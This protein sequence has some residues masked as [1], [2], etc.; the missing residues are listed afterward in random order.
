MRS[1]L[2]FNF[3]FAGIYFLYAQTIP[4]WFWK[5][6]KLC[7]PGYAQVPALPG[8]AS[9][10]FCVG[11]YEAKKVGSVAVS[12]PTGTPW[13]TITRAEAVTACQANGS[14]YDLIS[15]DQWQA[16]ARN[17]ENVASNWSSGVVGSGAIN[18][19]NSASTSSV[20][21]CTGT[22]GLYGSNG[23]SGCGS[24]VNFALKRTHTL[25]NGQVIWDFAGNV[26]EWVKDANMNLSLTQYI[27]QVTDATAKSLF[28]PGGTYTSLNSG[29]YGGLGL[30]GSFSA[31]GATFRGG[32]WGEGTS[33]G[34][35]RAETAFN[36]SDKFSDIGF[37]C[38][39]QIP[40]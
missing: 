34:I 38:V 13:G 32:N 15:N 40:P 7:P 29:E 17:I 5:N 19:G 39:Y 24:T 16:I 12:Q 22:D 30:L 35:F 6:P 27:S 26:N 28:G 25:S 33:S 20:V 2:F 31:G 4:V 23:G 11:T 36:T 3:F 1:I 10:D 18:R 37:R 9:T 8:Y 21:P 14:R